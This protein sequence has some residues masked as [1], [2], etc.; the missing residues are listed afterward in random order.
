MKSIFIPFGSYENTTGG[1]STFMY[2]LNNYLDKE[3]IRYHT[4]YKKGDSIFF[5]ITYSYDV[6][7]EV[8][9]NSGKIVQRLDGIYYPSKHG[10]RYLDLN[11][12][13]KKIY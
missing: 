3:N 10:G 13:I 4:K 12:D 8:K 1:P 9:K 11:K 6:L 2:N 5:P 7:K